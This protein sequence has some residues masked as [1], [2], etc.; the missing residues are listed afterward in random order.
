MD[1]KDKLSQKNGKI[2]RQVQRS[3]EWIQD[4][5]LL[6]LDETTYDKISISD[7]TA[8]AGVAR[9]T[10]YRNYRGKDDIIL[11]FLDSS[12]TDK[13]LIIA[14]ARDDRGRKVMT[15]TL[16][17]G[18]LFDH[19]QKL[20]KLQRDDTERLIFAYT[21]RLE[22][23]VIERGKGKV[24][25]GDQLLFRYKVKFMVGGSL[26][27]I[28]DWMKHDMPMATEKLGDLLQKCIN[29][30]DAATGGLPSLVIKIQY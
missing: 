11:Q 20:A 16:S 9:Q 18:G 25:R 22:D 26:R 5:L 15:I 27:M 10:F 3:R 13:F 28:L 21:Q 6:L 30:V 24:S 4:A 12:F 2:N 17:M 14:D 7:I 1:K 19:R 23:Q 8:R 29:A